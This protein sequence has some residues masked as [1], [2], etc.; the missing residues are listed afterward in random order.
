M[1]HG[2]SNRRTFHRNQNGG[3]AVGESTLKPGLT[4]GG[5]LKSLCVGGDPNAAA[6]YASSQPWS[7][8]PLIVRALKSAVTAATPQDASG[9]MRPI[10]LDFA[11]FLRPMTII[12][13][14]ALRRVVTGVRTFVGTG[15]ASGAFV[16]PGEAIPVSASAF[17]NGVVLH[18]ARIGAITILTQELA[19]S[20]APDARLI[21]AT[22]AAAG[23]AAAMDLAFAN[24]ANAGTADLPASVFYGAPSVPS[25]G[26]SLSAIDADVK[27]AVR[28]AVDAGVLLRAGGWLMGRRTALYLMMLRG[29]GGDRAFPEMLDGRLLDMPVIV[30]DAIAPV[31]SPGESI[32]GLVDAAEVLLADEGRSETTLSD[33]T[34][35][36]MLDNPTNNAAIGT[37]TSMVSMFQANSVAVRVVRYLRWQARRPGAAAY[38]SGVTF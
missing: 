26:S 19:R 1:T 33:R 12:G 31:G 32:I 10:E 20:S 13:R 21:L 16:G 8:G 2:P 29:T 5:Y 18:P 34:S 38:I 30:S 11:E 15:G 9:L 28:I 3:G 24:P 6:G 23:V 25:S 27:A 7:D 36:Q 35:L 14:L 37:A 4:Y 17:D 22:D